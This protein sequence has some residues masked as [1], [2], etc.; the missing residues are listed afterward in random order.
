MKKALTSLLI[1]AALLP[2]ALPV[3]GISQDRE[4][5]SNQGGSTLQNSMREFFKKPKATPRPAKRVFL[6]THVYQYEDRATL[7]H[8]KVSSPEI[9][10]HI[11]KYSDGTSRI[12]PGHAFDY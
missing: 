12:V 4:T 1:A 3:E 9:I 11:Q 6:G 10:F 8:D 5:L 2:F 7:K